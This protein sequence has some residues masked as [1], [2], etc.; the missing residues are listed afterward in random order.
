MFCALELSNTRS[1]KGS[2]FRN[3]Y[4]AKNG[5]SCPFASKDRISAFV[6]KFSDPELQIEF[7]E[8]G[9]QHTHLNISCIT[10]RKK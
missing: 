4:L 9:L 10:K 6:T 7:N 2:H 8:V 3:S 1:E 5:K